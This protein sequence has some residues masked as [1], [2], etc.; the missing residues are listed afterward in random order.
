MSW[1]RVRIA[2]F[3]FNLCLAAC[4]STGGLCGGAIAP[5][6]CPGAYPDWATSPYN[7]PWAVGSSFMVGQGSCT[8]ATESHA[9]GTSDAFAIDVDM[10]IG[11]NIL[12]ARAGIVTAIEGQYQDGNKQKAN[13][14]KVQHDDGTVAQYF[15]LTLNG[16]KVAVGERVTQGQLVAQSGNTG[17]STQPHLHFQVDACAGQG[18]IPVTFKNTAPNP[19]GLI[20]GQSYTA[21]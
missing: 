21:Q 17:D 20:D 5:G 4:S 13:F 19:S 9:A 15:H 18:S 10:P 14:V 12:A 7:L 16:P 1:L 11:T 2:L 6:T 8:G 3:G